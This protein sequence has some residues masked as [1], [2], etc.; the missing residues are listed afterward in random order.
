MLGKRFTSVTVASANARTN[1][2]IAKAYLR[3]F[4]CVRCGNNMEVSVTLWRTKKIDKLHAKA[5]WRRENPSG[6][7]I[8]AS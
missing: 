7:R 5:V 6:A 8:F 4:V 2:H 1:T 3:F